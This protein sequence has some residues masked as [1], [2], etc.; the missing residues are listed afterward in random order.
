MSEDLAADI[1][2]SILKAIE[3]GQEEPAVKDVLQLAYPNDGTRATLASGTTDLDFEAGTVM[4]ADG[5]VSKMSSSLR[6]TGLKAM[7]SA[8]IFVDQ[9][10]IIQFDAHDRMFLLANTWMHVNH[11]EF[12]RLR[13]T[14]T[15]N[16]TFQCMTSSAEE[17]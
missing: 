15:V 9:D 3:H 14:C 5:T 11:Y 6:K 2:F 4:I 16:T 10:S 7:Q 8:S 12:S 17:R 13:V 1:L